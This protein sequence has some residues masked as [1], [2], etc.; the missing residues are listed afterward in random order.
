[1]I[2][3]GL[4]ILPTNIESK[5]QVDR[6]EEVDQYSKSVPKDMKSK[7]SIFTEVATTYILLHTSGESIE[8]AGYGQ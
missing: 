4:S 3:N 5:I 7:Q 2:K 1:M 6:W 8:V